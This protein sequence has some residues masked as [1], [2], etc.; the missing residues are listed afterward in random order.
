MSNSAANR[1]SPLGLFP[2]QPTP[3]LY[4]CVVDARRTRP[5]SRRTEE[6][7]LHWIRRFILFHTGAHPREL[8][9]SDSPDHDGLHPGIESWWARG[10]QPPRPA[11]EGCLR[12]EQRD[13]P[14]QPVG[15]KLGGT[16]LNATEVVITKAVAAPASRRRF[17]LRPTRTGFIQVSLN[18][19][20]A[21]RTSLHDARVLIYSPTVIKT[22]TSL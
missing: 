22:C 20:W 19:S 13:Y 9:E 5:Y 3:R 6:A 8:A 2:A 14:D 4:D 21:D 17:R 15:L 10:P 1:R 11:A 18:I 12:R 7:Y 16:L